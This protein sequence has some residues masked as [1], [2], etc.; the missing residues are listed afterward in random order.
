MDMPLEPQTLSD[1][2]YCYEYFH[3]GSVR[4]EWY[5]KSQLHSVED[6]AA[7]I[8]EPE[9]EQMWYT[10]GMRHRPAHLGPAWIK[11]QTKTEV[12]Y[13]FGYIHRADGPAMIT[14]TDK[15]WYKDGR[16][17]RADGPAVIRD[18]APGRPLE[19]HW[20]G[21]ACK[22]FDHWSSVAAI[23]DEEKVMLKLTYG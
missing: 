19:W 11:P 6:H 4:H 5:W 8:I 2:E 14:A 21:I 23:S 10:H 16:L 7:V 13:K 20:Y 1:L 9:Q 17:H 3:D 15:K 12:Y 22:D 18:R